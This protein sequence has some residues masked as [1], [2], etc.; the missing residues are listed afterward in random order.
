MI[1][2]EPGAT[3]VTWPLDETVAIAELEEQQ[4]PSGID[5]EF[6]DED[7]LI[8]AGGLKSM[9]Q[10]L[11]ELEFVEVLGKREMD[12]RALAFVQSLVLRKALHRR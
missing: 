10:D 11:K 5:V 3:A 1:C 6:S 7:C 8:S 2:T 9:V 12:V 4:N